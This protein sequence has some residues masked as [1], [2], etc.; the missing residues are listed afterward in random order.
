MYKDVKS[1]LLNG[2]EDLKS[3]F[4]TMYLPEILEPVAIDFF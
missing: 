1:F 2:F 3:N 4:C